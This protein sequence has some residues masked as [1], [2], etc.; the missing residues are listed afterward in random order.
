MPRL[1]IV[2]GFSFEREG[3]LL[4]FQMPQRALLDLAHSWENWKAWWPSTLESLILKRSESIY[5]DALFSNL[6]LV[7]PSPGNEDTQL[8]P[9]YRF[10]MIMDTGPSPSVPGIGTLA[11]EA[12]INL[13]NRSCL[14]VQILHFL[15]KGSSSYELVK[16][17]RYTFNYWKNYRT[18]ITGTLISCNLILTISGTQVLEESANMHQGSGPCV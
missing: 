3:G 10:W 13:D 12:T 14:R 9:S 18:L 15:V 16:G 4:I 6:R 8:P 7:T 2:F 17:S 11:A 1:R 5:L